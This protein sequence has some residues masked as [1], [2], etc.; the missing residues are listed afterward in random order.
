M[1]DRRPR[2]GYTIKRDGRAQ[3]APS[4][5]RAPGRWSKPGTGTPFSCSTTRCG[6][7]RFS[8]TGREPIGVERVVHDVR[9]EKQRRQKAEG[10]HVLSRS[11]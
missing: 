7:Q 6:C 4:N 10:V 11:R 3:R 8:Q 5:A 9:I 2:S 1:D